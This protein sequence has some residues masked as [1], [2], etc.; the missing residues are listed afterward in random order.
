MPLYTIYTTMWQMFRGDFVKS[1]AEFTY[2]LSNLVTVYWSVYIKSNTVQTTTTMIIT[3]TG[4][5]TNKVDI[6]GNA[7]CWIQA[8]EPKKKRENDLITNDDIEKK[9]RYSFKTVS[10]R[11]AGVFRRT[12]T[13]YSF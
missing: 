2:A 10:T 13:H 4:S 6:L 5:L 3:T 7:E 12:K 1:W 8:L 11:N 9:W